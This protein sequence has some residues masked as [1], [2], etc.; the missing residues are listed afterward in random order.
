MQVPFQFGKT[1]FFDE[2]PFTRI[3]DENDE[4]FYSTARMVQHIDSAASAEISD[5]YS[6]LLTKTAK[7]WI[8]WAVGIRTY[9]MILLWGLL[10]G[11]E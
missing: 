3:D 1:S 10:P 6:Q 8:L 11:L 5:L 4:K 7:C 2:Y 9:E